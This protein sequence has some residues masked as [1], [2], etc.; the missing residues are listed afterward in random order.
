[1]RSE[2]LLMRQERR[3][4]AWI[5]SSGTIRE[6]PSPGRLEA[7]SP[8]ARFHRVRGCRTGHFDAVTQTRRRLRSA[9]CGWGPITPARA[10]R[11]QVVALIYAMVLGAT[12][13]EVAAVSGDRVRRHV[14]DDRRATELVAQR[15]TKAV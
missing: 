15:I 14:G 4:P 10:R 11:A 2:R 6:P 5:R 9:S 8:N 12:L 1:M 7:R 13:L 3:R